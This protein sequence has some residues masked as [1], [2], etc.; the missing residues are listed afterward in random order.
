M[1]KDNYS[2]IINRIYRIFFTLCTDDLDTETPVIGKPDYWVNYNLLATQVSDATSLKIWCL[3]EEDDFDLAAE[4]SRF[5]NVQS[6]DFNGPAF[7]KS[8]VFSTL[9]I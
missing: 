2:I 3:C 8:P 7:S 1:C 9:N 4:A 5:T 6:I